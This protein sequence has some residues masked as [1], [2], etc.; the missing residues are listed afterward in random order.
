MPGRIILG[1]FMLLAACAPRGAIVIDPEAAKVGAVHRI[2]VASNRTFQG[3]RQEGVSFGRIDVSV[4]PQRRP[5]T[6][7]YPKSGAK[8]DPR[9][10]FLVSAHQ[11][12]SRPEDFRA[13]LRR[14]VAARPRDE[15]DVVLFVHGYNNTFA[16]G[17]YRFAQIEHDMKLPGVPIHFS[18]PSRA[19]PLAYAADR[20]SVL[21]SRD[22]LTRSIA[23]AAD[24]G[25]GK[26]IL[27]AHS[28]GAELMMESLRQLAIAGDRRTLDRID[29]VV[30]LSP[31]IDVGL[32]R[33]QAHAIGRLP[34]PF[35]IFTSGR[36]KALDLSAL[37]SAEPVRLG[38]LTDARPLADLPVTLV[39]VG[40]FST[41]S[42]HFNVATSPALIQIL[43]QAPKLESVFS[44]DVGGAVGPLTRAALRV[45]RAAQI[46]IAPGF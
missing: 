18:W 14:A 7:S 37:I 25:S 15:R 28:M 30:L 23:L 29:A 3:R 11:S 42:G 33:M 13:D 36:D 2:Y 1:L 22:G 43:S 34:Q 5:G 40:A 41:G 19:Q 46:V 20:D 8:P 32:F 12:F 27:I 10:D 38:S 6:I 31:D 4:P 35:I 45:E 26:V 39:D 9:T 44:G 21:F 16:E 17:L 24:S